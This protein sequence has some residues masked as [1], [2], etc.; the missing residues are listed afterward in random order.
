[1]GKTKQ[2]LK[3]LGQKY[4]EL[5][6]PGKDGKPTKTQKA[7]SYIFLPSRIASDYIYS[8]TDERQNEIRDNVRNTLGLDTNSTTK[9]ASIPGYTKEALTKYGNTK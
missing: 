9:I 6:R 8:Q 5:G 4:M 2:I 3:L 1:M 7:I